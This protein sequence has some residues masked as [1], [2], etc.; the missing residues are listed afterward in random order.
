MSD[1]QAALDALVEIESI[2]RQPVKLSG[3]IEE[4]ELARVFDLFVR[5]KS[6]DALGKFEEGAAAL[7]DELFNK[8]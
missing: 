8:K 6:G 5:L 3:I 7:V 4:K 2:L 1:L